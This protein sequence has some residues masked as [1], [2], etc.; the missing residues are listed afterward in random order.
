M[1]ANNKINHAR[2]QTLEVIGAT[3]LSKRPPRSPRTRLGGYALLTRMLD[4]GRATLAGK[5]GEYH[6]NCPLDQHIIN[7]AG[8]D[9]KKLLAELKKGKGDGEI[10][11][12]IT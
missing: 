1:K 5:N 8:I 11:A 7:F 12:G 9:A 3:D 4:K 6:Y 2:F 10:L